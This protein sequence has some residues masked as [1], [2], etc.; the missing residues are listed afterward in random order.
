MFVAA[1]YSQLELRIL[2]HLSNDVTLRQY[3]SEKQGTCLVI[4]AYVCV[5]VILLKQKQFYMYVF[6]N[7]P[8][9]L[10]HLKGVKGVRNFLKSETQKGV[11]LRYPY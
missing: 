4:C 5:C 2:A 7:H 3:L 6:C 1:D 11:L 8:L 9:D 10:T